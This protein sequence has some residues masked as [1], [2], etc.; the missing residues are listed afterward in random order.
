MAAATSLSAM[1]HET[2]QLAAALQ[3]RVQQ[4]V[5]QENVDGFRFEPDVGR[6][7]VY[8]AGKRVI[9]PVRDEARVSSCIIG[10]DK[11]HLLLALRHPFEL[12]MIVIETGKVYFGIDF[13]DYDTL[14]KINAV[15]FSYK[16]QYL[17]V[18]GY[19]DIPV[20]FIEDI[21]TMEKVFPFPFINGL[22][23]LSMF[24]RSTALRD[25]LSDDERKLLVWDTMGTQFVII[26]LSQLRPTIQS[27]VSTELPLREV[28]SCKLL[29][30]TE[31]GQESILVTYKDGTEVLNPGLE[32]LID[33]DWAEAARL[34]VEHTKKEGN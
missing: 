13:S 5:R 30:G 23:E 34:I 7:V 31:S 24:A 28:A 10:D 27:S 6:V 12:K 1:R 22:I 2:K 3:S 25:L 29:P 26:D 9:L 20:I 15:I 4:P 32:Y 33:E 21:R 14:A 16:Y 19:T 18:L 8:L 11:E 17:I